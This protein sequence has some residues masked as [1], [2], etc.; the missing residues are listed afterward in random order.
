MV[1][2]EADPLLDETAYY[3]DLKVALVAAQPVDPAAQ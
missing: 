3:R 2:G 1:A